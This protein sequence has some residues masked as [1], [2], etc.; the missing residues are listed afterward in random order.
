VCLHQCI[1]I[2]IKN[3]RVSLYNLLFYLWQHATKLLA[4]NSNPAFILRYKK[5]QHCSR[6]YFYMA[7]VAGHIS[8]KLRWALQN[9]KS[10]SKVARTSWFSSITTKKRP[11]L[12]SKPLFWQGWLDS[13]LSSLPQNSS[14]NCFLPN[15]NT[16]QSCLLLIQIQQLFTI[17]KYPN[18][19]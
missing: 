12:T 9:Y 13:L 7:G 18:L 17:K 15:D 6:G 3:K 2:I 11:T 8:A 4:P 5:P 16:Q 10:P 1:H 19:N 14:P